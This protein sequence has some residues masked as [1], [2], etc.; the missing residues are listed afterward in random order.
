MAKA[1]GVGYPAKG[2]PKPLKQ[3][4]IKHGIIPIVLKGKKSK[5]G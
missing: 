1:T 3:I 4:P 2:G 5:K